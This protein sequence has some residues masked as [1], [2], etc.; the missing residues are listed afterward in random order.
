MPDNQRYIES[1]IA[2]VRRRLNRHALLNSLLWAAAVSAGLL[3]AVG[4][5]YVLPG[6]SVPPFWYAVAVAVTVILAGAI[7]FV[8]RVS[9][10]RAARFADEFFELEDS[11][12][13]CR[14]FAQ[15][16]AEG[17]FFDLQAKQTDNC[18]ARLSP[19]AIK[20]RLPGRLAGAIFVLAV[21]GLL[22]GLKSPSQAVQ[23]R[24]A[25]QQQTLQQ[26]EEMNQ[27]L[28]QLIDELE[29][30]SKGT[31]ERELIDPSRL[32]KWVN[33]LKATKDQ[34]EALRQYARLE[35]KLA[36]ATSRLQQQHD[37][38]LLRRSAEELDKDRATRELAKQ[39]KLKDYEEAIEELRELAPKLEEQRREQLSEQRKELARLKAASQRMSSAAM[40]LRRERNSSHERELQRLSRNRQLS[41]KELQDL[42]NSAGDLEDNIEGLEDAVA[43][44]EKALDDAE[45]EKL[46]LGQCKEGTLKECELGRFVVAD[47]VDKLG[48]KLYR[49]HLKNNAKKKLLRL[50]RACSQCQSG[51]CNSDS[52]F[53][54]GK[55]P[56]TGTNPATR[57]EVDDL[58]D[59]GQY[60]QLRGIKGSGPSQ[61]AIEAAESG[62]GASNRRHVER[63]H[64]FRHQVESFVTR[65]D[66]PENVKAGVKN[67]F[68][69]IHQE[70]E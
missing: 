69:N 58:V 65:E 30:E 46:E 14:H 37:E 59:N 55:S 40:A 39:L 5:G 33:E 2:A 68:Q 32:R 22:L 15:R 19:N 10:E 9:A 50:C 6:Y 57:D 66:V 36:G 29:E 53:A 16:G 51:L 43:E 64:E 17:G 1:F 25:R 13:S 8:R 35:R 27:F 28:E 41:E 42:N 20:F 56:G 24:L 52:P 44:W 21:A 48:K 26:T 34:K 23:Q 62:S 60:T 61:T 4:L 3:V 18:I 12:T 70:V 38:A 31:D 47:E 49:L 11:V 63:G 67:Y 45:A 7:W 54:G